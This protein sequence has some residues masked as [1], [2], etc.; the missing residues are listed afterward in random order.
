[1]DKQSRTISVKVNGTEAKY[2]EKKK[3]E[4]DWMVVES[5]RPKNVV[6]FQKSKVAST[7]KNRKKWSNTLI[8]IVATAIIIGT[9]FGMGMLQLL[10]GQGATGG[11]E[12]TASKQ[13]RKEESKVGGTAEQ[14]PAPKRGKNK[15]TD[16]NV[17]GS[18]EIIFCSRRNLFF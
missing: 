1:M 9:A 14:T 5:E 18:N 4:F 15:S 7:E 12:V 6:L 17:I 3:D 8:A 13:M 2:E 10:K 16:R 11:S